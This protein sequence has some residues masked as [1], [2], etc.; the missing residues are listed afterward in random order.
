M[1][2]GIKRRNTIIFLVAIFFLIP[3]AISAFLVFYEAPTCFDGK[4]NGSESGIDCG[5]NCELVCTSE[6]LAPSVIWK[7][8]FEVSPGVYNLVAYVENPN[9]SAGVMKAPY[10]FE[11]FNQDNVLIAKREGSVRLYP[12]TVIPIIETGIETKKQNAFRVAFN[13]SEDL[14]FEKEEPL[15]AVLIVKNE[16]YLS[17]DSPRVTATI[18]NISLSKVEDIDI[19]VL[20]Y[21]VFDNVITS[22]STFVENLSG[23]ASK[24]IVFTWPDD[25]LEE[26]SR[27]EIIPI[28]E[29]KFSE[30]N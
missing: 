1:S 3:I 9:P 2:W 6:T 19:V 25:F 21:D 7:R 26:V 29:P 20:L 11:L 8:Y 23:E 10:T 15:P 24:D 14:I 28:Y 13:F 18:E 5:G 12:K 4:Q 17:K 27:I 30:I 22:S 16:N